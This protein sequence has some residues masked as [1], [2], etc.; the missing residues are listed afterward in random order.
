MTIKVGI[1]GGIGSGKSIICSVFRLL[2]AP[3][4]EADSTA[5]KLMDS[6][7]EIIENIIALF[8]PE[9]YSVNKQLNRK[10]IAG[11]IFNDDTQREK[12]NQII[13]PAVRKAFNEWC[14]NQNNPYVIHEAAIL[15]ESGFYKMMDYTV[16][17]TAPEKIRIERVIKRDNITTK[18]VKERIKKQWPDSEKRKLATIEI[19]N[20]NKNLIIP[21]IIK[22]DE[23]LRLYGKIW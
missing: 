6:D 23:N 15:F 5:K 21:K 19:A 14:K 18:E 17:V 4:F 13:H 1:T 3:V 16:L 11:I 8:G 12:L 9:T 7:N 10:R 22:I 2:G 20:D